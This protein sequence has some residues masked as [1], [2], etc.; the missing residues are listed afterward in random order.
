[1]NALEGKNG[2]D[3]PV[4]RKTQKDIIEERENLQENTENREETREEKKSEKDVLEFSEPTI[5]IN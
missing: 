1:M 3:G 2:D 5:N 4:R